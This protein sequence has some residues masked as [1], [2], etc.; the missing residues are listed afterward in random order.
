MTFL[1]VGA[2]IGEYAIIAAS[3]VGQSGEVHAFEP[4]P[5]LSRL[6]AQNVAINGFRNV[7]VH[8]S[9]IAD[10]EGTAEFHLNTDPSLSCLAPP[11][12]KTRNSG[13][14][15][16]R[17]SVH[18]TTLDEF[19]R[20]HGRDIALIKIDVEGAELPVFL[21]SRELLRL[22]PGR[23]PV[24]VFEYS[25]TNYARFGYDLAG[26]VS[27][28]HQHGYNVHPVS[29]PGLIGPRAPAELLCAQETNNFVAIKHAPIPT[30]Q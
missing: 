28:L 8:Q 4:N 15:P 26:L 18:T 13:D 22:P 27:L 25:R 14:D 9:A 5:T 24:W 19:H 21:G 30:P 12:T 1:D 23:A 6:L 17:L 7:Q 20:H 3:R 29:D 16:S 10:R 2:H 11:R